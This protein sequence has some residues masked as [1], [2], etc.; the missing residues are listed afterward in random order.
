MSYRG[1]RCP[2]CSTMQ[3]DAQLVYAKFTH[4]KALKSAVTCSSLSKTTESCVAMI[5]ARTLLRGI[6][7][8][9]GLRWSLFTDF[10][11][12]TKI[13][14][15]LV[16]VSAAPRMDSTKHG[17]GCFLD[18]PFSWRLSAHSPVRFQAHI[19]DDRVILFYDGPANRG[20]NQ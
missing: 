13:F 18:R 16:A 15:G 11:I 12:V 3:D 7:G 1:A 2:I 5:S 17:P 20:T 6:D 8:Y 4:T 14:N 10:R 9:E 19:T